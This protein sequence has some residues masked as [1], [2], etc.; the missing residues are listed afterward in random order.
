[1]T[2]KRTP[3]SRYRRTRN[4]GSPKTRSRKPSKPVTKSKHTRKPPRRPEPKKQIAY[5]YNP[6][7]G[8]LDRVDLSRTVPETQEN[9]WLGYTGCAG[10]GILKERMRKQLLKTGHLEEYPYEVFLVGRGKW[11]AEKVK[12]HMKQVQVFNKVNSPQGALGYRGLNKRKT[13]SDAYLEPQGAAEKIDWTDKE[14]NDY[15]YIHVKY[16]SGPMVDLIESNS[17]KK[18]VDFLKEFILNSAQ[19][20]SKNLKSFQAAAQ[21]HAEKLVDTVHA[22][23]AKKK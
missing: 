10:R 8:E 18:A 19:S 1:M 22:V 16:V 9:K 15:E 21:R 5:L 12:H 14:G 23:D 13:T 4:F 3:S 17:R 6:T 20:K 11:T 2:Y 7:D